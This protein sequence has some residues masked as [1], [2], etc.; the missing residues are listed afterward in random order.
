MERCDLELVL[1]VQTQG[2]LAKAAQALR[3]TPPV[4]TKRLAALESQLGVRLFQRT[5]RRV[6]PTTEIGRAS[7]R[8][9]V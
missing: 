3:L 9:R 8:E 4:V 7:C 2:S 6:S 5:T 1:A